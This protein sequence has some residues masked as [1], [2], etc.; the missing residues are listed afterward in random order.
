[1][2]R[3]TSHDEDNTLPDR[4]LIQDKNVVDIVV[5]IVEIVGVFLLPKQAI[6]R[7]K[8]RLPKQA[9]LRYLIIV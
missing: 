9:T 8:A 6:L 7:Y 5:K 1:M 2:T 4:Q 3:D